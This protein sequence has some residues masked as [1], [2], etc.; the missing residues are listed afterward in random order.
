MDGG[1]GHVVRGEREGVHTRFWWENP[2]E[3]DHLENLDVDRSITL[4]WI[5]KKFI[6]KL[7]TGL[8]LFRIGESG[9]L[10]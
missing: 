6:R 4:K 8:I 7:W 3:K 1:G 2:R 9:G 5:V 10:F